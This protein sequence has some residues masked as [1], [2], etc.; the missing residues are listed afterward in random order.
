MPDDAKVYLDDLIKKTVE[1]KKMDI[2]FIKTMTAKQDSVDE[3]PLPP[4]PYDANH[5]TLD[6]KRRKRNRGTYG[7]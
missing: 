5:H 4:P 3:K 2:S 7:N 1:N 6:E